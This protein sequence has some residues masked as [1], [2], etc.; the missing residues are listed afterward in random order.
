MNFSRWGGSTSGGGDPRT[1]KAKGR[2][3]AGLSHKTFGVLANLEVKNIHHHKRSPIEQNDVAADHDV[4]AFRRR[5]RK[6]PLEVFGAAHNLFLKSR[7]QSAPH[8]K[9]AFKAWGQPI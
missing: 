3:E 5:R 4:L 7:R 8:Y 6:A 9:L 1:D 2:P